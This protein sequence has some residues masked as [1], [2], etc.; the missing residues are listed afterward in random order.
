MN[1]KASRLEEALR[2]RQ[3]MSTARDAMKQV[4]WNSQVGHHDPIGMWGERFAVS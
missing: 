1:L 3:E 4:S 2:Q